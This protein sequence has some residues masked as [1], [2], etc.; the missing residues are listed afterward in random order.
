VRT[1][2]S[3]PGPRETPESRRLPQAALPRRCFERLAMK[4][5]G[6]GLLEAAAQGLA[7]L[8]AL[9]RQNPKRASDPTHG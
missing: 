4:L 2:A 8:K 6:G 5:M 3:A 9:E 7:T 1:G